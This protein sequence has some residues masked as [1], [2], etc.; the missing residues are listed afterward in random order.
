MGKSSPLYIIYIT[1]LIAVLQLIFEWMS[2]CRKISL[3]V[4]KGDC[5]SECASAAPKYACIMVSVLAE[6]LCCMETNFFE[7]V[8]V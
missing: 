4:E 3:F 6:I 1:C 2:L 5:H 8:P 7:N